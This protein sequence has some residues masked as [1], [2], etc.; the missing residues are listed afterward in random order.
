M[1]NE[2]VIARSETTKQS[3]ITKGFLPLL[4]C[5]AALAM[6]LVFFAGTAQASWVKRFGVP[7]QEYR[8]AIATTDTAKIT[9]GFYLTSFPCY[10]QNSSEYYK[11]APGQNIITLYCLEPPSE[12]YL[13][14]VTKPRGAFFTRNDSMDGYMLCPVK[15]SGPGVNSVIPR[16]EVVIQEC[17]KR[18]LNSKGNRQILGMGFSGAGKPV[19]EAMAPDDANKDAA[20]AESKTGAGNVPE[21]K[22]ETQAEA[23][24]EGKTLPPAVEE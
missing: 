5:F 7:D 15:I 19:A 14:Y 6:T 9:A 16:L 4:D 21:P 8:V 12:I 17:E 22:A 20:K 3:R 10:S 23:E 1:R 2:H 13:A 18:E 11:T 24:R